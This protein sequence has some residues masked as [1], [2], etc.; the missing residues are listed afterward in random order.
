MALDPG[1]ETLDPRDARLTAAVE[2]L[3]APETR[4]ETDAT[5]Y[6]SDSFVNRHTD[7]ESLEAFCRACPCE[8]DTIGG[9]QGL[10]AAERDEFVAAR[11]DFETWQEMTQ[12]AAATD[13]V[14]LLTD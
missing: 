12:H 8:R 11:T 6:F 3:L 9:V 4:S 13:L 2:R 10:D 14:T 5:D 1:V 7:F